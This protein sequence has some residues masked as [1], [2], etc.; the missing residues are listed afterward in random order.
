[1]EKGR[2]GMRNGRE[3]R[4]GENGRCASRVF[5]FLCAATRSPIPILTLLVW[6]LPAVACSTRVPSLVETLPASE[7]DPE[8][9]TELEQSWDAGRGEGNGARE[10]EAS[11][12]AS[13]NVV[14]R[15]TLLG[16]ERWTAGRRADA[17]IP[18]DAADFTVRFRVDEVLEGEYGPDTL[19]IA[20]R[21][22]LET[23][24]HPIAGHEEFTLTLERGPRDAGIYRVTR[25]DPPAAILLREVRESIRR[26]A[27]DS[28][29]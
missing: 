26:E 28:P 5:P 24:A 16:S 4:H 18:G 22:P 21:S 14:V 7:L 6:L 2:Q 15:A 10:G 27:G 20:L 25:I 19:T 17:R 11:S 12:L 23:F 1:M 3:V 29:E 13:E 8:G 9:W